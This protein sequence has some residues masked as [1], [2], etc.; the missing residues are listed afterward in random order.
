MEKIGLKI[1]QNVKTWWISM[2]EPL[3]QVMTKYK[4]LIMKISQDNASIAQAE[5]KTLIMEISQDNASI[6][7]ARFNLILFCDLPLLLG[8]SCLLP[9]LEAVNAL[10]KFAQGRD[11][12]ICGNGSIS[13]C[14]KCGGKQF[15]HNHLGL[16]Y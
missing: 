4:T 12:F 2:L 11:I 13:K 9:L 15:C 6:A 1:L 10:I 16:G 3:K 14:F 8:L 7:Q 5:Y